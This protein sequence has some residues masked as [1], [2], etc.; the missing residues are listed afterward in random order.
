M[1]VVFNDGYGSPLTKEFIAEVA[2]ERFSFVATLWRNN[3]VPVRRRKNHIKKG[4]S[5]I[6]GYMLNGGQLVVIEVKTENDKLSAEQKEFLIDVNKHGGYG[7]VAQGM[8]NGSINIYLYINE[9]S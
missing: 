2:I 4:V 7:Y 5:D 8:R 1:S 9:K 6:I 3:N